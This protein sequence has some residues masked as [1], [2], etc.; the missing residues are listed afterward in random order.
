VFPATLF[1]PIDLASNTHTT[2]YLPL[3][4]YQIAKHSINQYRFCSETRSIAQS[5]GEIMSW[6]N[7]LQSKCIAIRNSLI[8]IGIIAPPGEKLAS[9][10]QQQQ[11]SRETLLFHTLPR[12]PR[13]RN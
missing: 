9:L 4:V 5:E 8:K 10:N 7:F 12:P 3:Y 11:K 6:Q 1:S 13:G 2:N